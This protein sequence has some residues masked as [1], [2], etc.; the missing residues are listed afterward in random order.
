[1]SGLIIGLLPVALVLAMMALNPDYIGLLFKD[2]RGLVLLATGGFMMLTGILLIRKI[3]Q[4][5]Y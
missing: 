4:I 3:I 2:P 1:L 5:D